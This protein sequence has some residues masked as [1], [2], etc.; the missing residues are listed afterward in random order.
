MG[1]NLELIQ[2]KFTEVIGNL[3]RTMEAEA[4]PVA[5]GRLQEAITSLADQREKYVAAF[6]DVLAHAKKTH[7]EA[8]QQLDS[9]RA[10]VE[11][12]KKNLEA[13][14][15]KQ[16]AM[17]QPKPAPAAPPVDPELGK[18]LREEL[19]T[20]FGGLQMPS[21]PPSG[22]GIGWNDWLASKKPK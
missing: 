13:I 9:A 15:A 22:E 12:A 19:L 11:E 14:K 20:R 2:Q 8:S 6:G 5:K 16:E 1:V 7:A 21:R 17:K 3:Q 10:K 18:K 4:D